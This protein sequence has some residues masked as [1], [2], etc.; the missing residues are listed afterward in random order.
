MNEI[1]KSDDNA[2]TESI[3]I[4]KTVTLLTAPLIEIRNRLGKGRSLHG[5]L[6][7]ARSPHCSW[8]SNSRPLTADQQTAIIAKLGELQT[9]FTDDDA[10]LGLVLETWAP[11]SQITSLV[12]VLG[13]GYTARNGGTSG[14]AGALLAALVAEDLEDYDITGFSRLEPISAPVIALAITRL[15]QHDK[16]FLPSPSEFR[17]ECVQARKRV[18][19]LRRNVRDMLSQPIPSP[20]LLTQVRS[21]HALIPSAPTTTAVLRIPGPWSLQRIPER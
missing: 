2:I 19:F 18:S 17:D 4:A 10:A 3:A 13:L 21:Q 14:Y 5:S 11:P 8:D 12:G 1:T 6:A 9:Q 7:R 20:P 15:W 16:K